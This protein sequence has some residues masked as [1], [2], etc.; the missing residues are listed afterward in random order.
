MVEYKQPRDLETAAGILGISVDS[1]KG[2][3]RDGRLTAFRVGPKKGIRIPQAEID[4]H[5]RESVIM[6]GEI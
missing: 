5:I 6:P 3:I 2:L 4:R 1:V